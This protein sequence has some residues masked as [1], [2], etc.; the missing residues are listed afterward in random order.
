[1]TLPLMWFETSYT[2]IKKW[3]TEGLSL[4]EAESALDT[5]LTDNNPISLEMADYVAE[6]WTCR[7]IQMLDADARRTLMRIWDER[8]IAAQT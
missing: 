8:E 1:M 6:N 3:D 4:L 7:R 5:Y 2:R